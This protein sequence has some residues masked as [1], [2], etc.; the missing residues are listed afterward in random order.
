MTIRSFLRKLQ[1]LGDVCFVHLKTMCLEGYRVFYFWLQVH[2]IF[3]TDF[4]ANVLQYTVCWTDEPIPHILLWCAYSYTQNTHQN[5]WHTKSYSFCTFL[6]AP[7]HMHAAIP[8]DYID[9][10]VHESNQ[11][12]STSLYKTRAHIF[13]MVRMC[14]RRCAPLHWKRGKSRRHLHHHNNLCFKQTH[15]PPLPSKNQ[16]RQGVQLLHRT[17]VPLYPQVCVLWTRACTNT[18]FCPRSR[19]VA[20]DAASS[21]LVML[22]TSTYLALSTHPILPLQTP[23]KYRRKSEYMYI[24]IIHAVRGWRPCIFGRAALVDDGGGGGDCGVLARCRCPLGPTWVVCMVFEFGL[25]HLFKHVEHVACRFLI[26]LLLVV[27]PHTPTYLWYLRVANRVRRD[28]TNE[29]SARLYYICTQRLCTFC[30]SIHS[31]QIPPHPLLLLLFCIALQSA[32]SEFVHAYASTPNARFS[33][34]FRAHTL[35]WAYLFPRVTVK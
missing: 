5:V 7:K 18:N 6:H 22:Y 34:L 4:S 27:R 25:R 1:W 13:M 35:H 26:K 10:D 8:D 21:S 33:P 31:I 16:C 32:D 24:I 15:P 9:G 29:C 28:S 30:H 2:T 20:P 11:R 14:R 12:K 3:P 17:G 23:I 19:A